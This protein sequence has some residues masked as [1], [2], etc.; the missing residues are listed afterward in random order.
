[1]KW[2]SLLLEGA[3]ETH[4]IKAAYLRNALNFAR[5]PRGDFPGPRSDFVIG[6][7]GED[8]KL[9]NSLRLAFEQLNY[10]VQDRRVK[11]IHFATPEEF[12]TAINNLQSAPIQVLFV[13]ENANEQL[14]DWVEICGK[15]PILLISDHPDFHEAGGHVTLTPNPDSEDRY[16]YRIHLP[17][18]KACK[19]RFTAEFLRI[20]TTVNVISK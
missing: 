5:W 17:N 14:K 9:Q 1:M 10:R 19:L 7:A 11:L 20:R 3:S 2:N 6:F 16:I 4:V 13:T 12:E 8:E 18:L 15:L